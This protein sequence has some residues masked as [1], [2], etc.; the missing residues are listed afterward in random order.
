MDQSTKLDIKYRVIHVDPHEHSMIVRYWIDE[1]N[2][3]DQ[4]NEF[5]QDST[6][7]WVIKRDENG[8]PT[9]CRSDVSITIY[10]ENVTPEKIDE[11]IRAHAPADW[12]RLKKR[13]PAHHLKELHGHSN[14]FEHSPVSPPAG[15]SK[16]T[17]T[18]E[19]IEQLLESKIIKKA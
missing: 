2:E 17:M 19:E 9:R 15:I 18:E 5:I 8:F 13:Q 1:F 7:E 14:S 16:P 4:A 12:L 11:I 6:G 10:E 3:D